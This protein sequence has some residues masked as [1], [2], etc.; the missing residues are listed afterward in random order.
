MNRKHVKKMQIRRAAASDDGLSKNG[1]FSNFGDP[2][3]GEKKDVSDAERLRAGEVTTLLSARFR[4]RLSSFSTQITQKDQIR[5]DGADFEIVGIKEVDV[6]GS[7][8]RYLE[9]S[10]AVV[11]R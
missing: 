10:A 7:T 2:I 4:V 3:F 9:I 6:K 11:R 1:V 5:C 8:R